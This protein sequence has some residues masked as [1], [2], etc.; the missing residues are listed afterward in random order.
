MNFVLQDYDQDFFTIQGENMQ[1][2]YGFPILK[3]D[4]VSL[5]II[6]DQNCISLEVL[7]AE[8][9]RRSYQVEASTN[10]APVCNVT[11]SERTMF[12]QI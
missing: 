4:L 10:I 11:G 7:T 1:P 3:K 9:G 8:N 5:E 6:P 2:Y 12:G